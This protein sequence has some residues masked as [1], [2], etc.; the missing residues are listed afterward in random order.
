MVLQFTSTWARK[1]D[2]RWRTARWR[3]SRWWHRLGELEVGERVV[4]RMGQTDY[5]AAGLVEENSRRKVFDRKEK[6]GRKF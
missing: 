6:L 1:G 2:C 5:T 4:G 3:R